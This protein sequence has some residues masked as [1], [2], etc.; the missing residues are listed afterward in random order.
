ML[1][2]FAVQ[3]NL[4]QF[5]LNLKWKQPKIQK[6]FFIDMQLFM[7]TLG[8]YIFVVSMNKYLNV[9]V[10]KRTYTKIKRFSIFT[11]HFILCNYSNYYWSR[12]IFIQLYCIY[13]LIGPFL[14]TLGFCLWDGSVR[15][16]SLCLL[17]KGTYSSITD[18]STQHLVVGNLSHVSMI[19]A[20]AHSKRRVRFAPIC[21]GTM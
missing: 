9:Q 6:M 5:N 7:M 13:K 8:L 15:S 16:A 4:I 20:L 10:W 12:L 1:L 19:V 21:L 2:T 11:C 3:A 18:Y 14:I 17:Q